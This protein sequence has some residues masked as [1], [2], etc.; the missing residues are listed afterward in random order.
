MSS[1]FFA[2]GTL[3]AGSRG[4]CESVAGE[5]LEGLALWSSVLLTVPA[6]AT[7]DRAAKSQT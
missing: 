1:V 4:L 3:D 2:V 5:G 6:E 7:V